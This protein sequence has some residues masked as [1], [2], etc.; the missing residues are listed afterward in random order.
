MVDIGQ[1]GR[2][3]DNRHY[4]LRSSR[5]KGMVSEHVILATRKIF[6]RNNSIVLIVIYKK[7][8]RSID[9]T[10]QRPTT[11]VLSTCTFPKIN[12]LHCNLMRCI[13]MRIERSKSLQIP[14]PHHAQQ[15]LVWERP[16]LAAPCVGELMCALM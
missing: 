13:P 9:I 6:T 3:I 15:W 2:P 10:S 12:L 1:C 7:C 4:K 5:G 11:N 16:L 14:L 8:L